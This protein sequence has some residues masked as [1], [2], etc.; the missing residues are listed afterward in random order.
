[1]K[2]V[3]LLFLMIGLLLVG[4]TKQD[5]IVNPIADSTTP[6]TPTNPVFKSGKFGVSY[7]RG[8]SKV[9]AVGDTTTFN[10]GDLRGSKSFYF[11]I[12]NVGGSNIT[13]INIKSNDSSVVVTPS[14]INVLVPQGQSSI[15]QT[16]K[17]NILDGILTE[18]GVGSAPLQ[19]MGDLI[20]SLD[21]TG[22]TNDS[23]ITM[24]VNMNMT[25][26]IMDADIFTQNDST[27]ITAVIPP[28]Q[29]WYIP[30]AD[31]LLF[32]KNTGNTKLGIRFKLMG[33][34]FS[35]VLK[36]TSFTMNPNEIFKFNLNVNGYNITD[37]SATFTITNLEH[38]TYDV[39]KFTTNPNY[40]FVFTVCAN[41]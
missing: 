28:A 12:E 25:S 3:Y 5:S 10:L 26:Y 14:T 6:T 2:K 9:T 24:H 39:N 38:T 15:L 36:D 20:K 31:S 27:R 8:L 30:T 33:M 32:F 40:P 18:N 34:M 11:I 41:Q 17:I 21:I 22:Y 29:T 37:V 23:L 19:S 1:M 7:M 4:C 16:V 35:T 13:S